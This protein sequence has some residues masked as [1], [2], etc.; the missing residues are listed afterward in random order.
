MIKFLYFLVGMVFTLFSSE[1]PKVVVG[2][3][4]SYQMDKVLPSQMEGLTHL[5]YF[6]TKMPS[7]GKFDS[8]I[9]ESTTL[10]RLKNIKKVIGCELQICIGGWERSQGFSQLVQD[11]QARL[12]FISEMLTFCTT[13]GFDGIDY[14]WEYPKTESEISLFGDFLI[15]SSREF[16]KQGLSVSIA[17]AGW[18]KF[19]HEVY[20]S[21]DRVHLM[22][23]D[24]DFPQATLE[25]TIS[26][27]EQ[28]VNS[29][30]PNE[31]IVLGL[32]FYGRNKAGKSK[33]YEQ[34]VAMGN[35]FSELD[36]VENYAFNSIDT[37]SKKLSHVVK[38][39]LAGV[40]IWEISQDSVH[41]SY[42]ILN[43][44]N[45]KIKFKSNK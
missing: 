11:E 9:V 18:Q 42:S 17:Q 22:S 14:D 41:P 28:V 43:F 33:T 45:Q 29:G 3:L 6:G 20:H 34:L 35:V 30:C 40:M 27:I 7:D 26:D 19:S 5:I 10:E 24:H 12:S 13:H 4:P 16:H 23:Y 21:I 2:Y 37:I 31:K 36:Q 8:Q 15:E 38:H 39:N 32:P 25:K 44:I 1:K